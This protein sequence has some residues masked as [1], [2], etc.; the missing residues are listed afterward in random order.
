[1]AL[2]ATLFVVFRERRLRESLRALVPVYLALV[3]TGLVVQVVKGW[4]ATPRPLAVFG[5]AAVHVVLDPLYLNGFPSGHSAS[6]ATLA[7]SAWLR[8][9]A[10]AWP[11]ILLAFLGGISRI[12]VG[13]HWTLDVAGGFA[14]GAL[15][16]FVTAALVDAL[17]WA[18]RGALRALRRGGDG[19][20]PGE[21]P[22]PLRR[23]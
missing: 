9:R 15:M 16:A 2:I 22:E 23:P 14:L 5:P 8:Y 19:S 3:L 13:A 1:M 17:F 20:G 21:G 18:G 7:A 11:L 4:A 12:Y 10:R 6:A